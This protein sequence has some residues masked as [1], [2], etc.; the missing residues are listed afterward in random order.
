MRAAVALLLFALCLRA[1]E[2]EDRNKAA[3]RVFIEQAWIQ[4][5]TD[6][7]PAAGQERVARTWCVEN[8][9]C[10]G[11]AVL[12]QAAEGDRVTT[13][14]M[15]RQTPKRPVWKALA[16]LFG[17]VPLELPMLTVLR[18]ENGQIVEGQNLHDDLALYA[19]MGVVNAMLVFVFAL[20]GACGIALVWLMNKVVRKT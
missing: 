2:A 17:R 8:G 7:A 5:R 11:S 3:A 4:G 13:F 16:H 14:W 18:F 9:D 15:L 12:W 19:G 6:V 20:G 1:G 10:S